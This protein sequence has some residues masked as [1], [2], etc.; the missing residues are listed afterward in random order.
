MQLDIF[1]FATAFQPALR[2][3]RL[4]LGKDVGMH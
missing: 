2:I 4:G 1:Q 3:E